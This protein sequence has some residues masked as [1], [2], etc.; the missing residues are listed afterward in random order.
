VIQWQ[1]REIGRLSELHPSL[2]ETGRAAVLDIDLDVLRE[3]TPARASYTPVRRFPTSAFDLSIIAGVREPAGHLERAIRR[4]SGDL[5]ESV[6]YVREYQGERLPE[7]K[8]SV[9]FRVV[10]GAS[11]RTLTADEIAGLRQRIIDGLTDL[12]YELRV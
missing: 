9:S 6:E 11:D 12:G 10:V 3:L 2:V 5:T 8:K 7:G 4:L 1:G